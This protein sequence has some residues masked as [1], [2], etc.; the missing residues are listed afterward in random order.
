MLLYDILKS[1]NIPNNTVSR[2]F[3]KIREVLGLKTKVLRS[4]SLIVTLIMLLSAMA[5]CVPS[6]NVPDSTTTASGGTTSADTSVTTGSKERLDK[7]LYIDDTWADHPKMVAGFNKFVSEQLGY[8]FEL[9]PIPTE[10]YIEKIN[11]MLLSGDVPDLL[12]LPDNP[13]GFCQYYKNGFLVPLNE[14]FENSSKLDHIDESIF[15]RYTYNDE[16]YAMPMQG[17]DLKVMYLRQDWLDNLGLDFPET[18]DELY[19]VLKAFTYND[20]DQNGKDDTI[21]MTLPKYVH[22]QHPLFYAF[23]ATYFFREDENGK[24]IDGFTQPQMMDALNYVKKLM[25]EGLFDNEWVTTTNS[26]Q[27]EK[28]TSG[29]AGGVCYWDDRYRWYNVETQKNFPEAEWRMLPYVK[30]PKGHYGIFE[31]G[32]GNPIT[33][34]SK[35]KNA[36]QAFEYIEWRWGTKEGAWVD[37]H[38]VPVDYIDDSVYA[39][40]QKLEWAYNNGKPQPSEYLKEAGN[41]LIAK[42][43]LLTAEIYEK[44]FDFGTEPYWADLAYAQIRPELEEAMVVQPYISM[45]NEWYAGIAGL[46]KDKKDELIT[47]YLYGDI[48]QE[49]MYK[50][51]DSWWNKVNGPANLKKINESR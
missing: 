39:Y 27:R 7:I 31:D 32:I 14:F 49:D 24:I 50:Q 48:T 12:E 23:D 33:I 26:M 17:Y 4:V 29:F 2:H 5:G 22:D 35:C 18:T 8:E 9:R 37:N 47:K 25:D 36:E 3:E 11:V 40:E 15:E 38:R 21:G 1:R 19:N 34:T 45:E 44:P 42:P 16:W 6:A 51:W 46:I 10:T 13:Y 41:S 43:I 30:G 28:T 20:P